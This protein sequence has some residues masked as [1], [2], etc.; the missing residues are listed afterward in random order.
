MK[1][2]LA[3]I[4]RLLH[5]TVQKSNRKF[6]LLAIGVLLLILIGAMIFSHL[7]SKQNVIALI[8]GEPITA[9][10]LQEKISE[11]PDFYRQYAKEL[12][13]Q[14][15]DDYINEQLIYQKAHKFSPRYRAKINKQL[16]RYR[17]ELLIKEYLED[18]VLST[19]QVTQEELKT[20]YNS[21]LND[22]LLPERL[23]LYE[24]VVPTQESAENIIKRLSLGEDFGEI[25]KKES[26]GSAKEKGGDLGIIVR[27]Q[28]M[29]ELEAIVFSMKSGDILGKVVKTENGFHI[30]RVG[31]RFPSQIQSLEEATPNI[32]KIV[33]TQKKRQ[34]LD[35]YVAKLKEDAQV[36]IHKEKL[37]DLQ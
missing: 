13:Q 2:Y 5:K 30:L 20:Y 19:I 6:L 12:P 31:E 26:Q 11:Y 37:G 36:V 35:A 33:L 24:I 3:Q 21:H 32:T 1:K 9:T 14:A 28:L 22:F 25:A 15:L 27:G 16:S 8:N 4:R 17:R 18:Q 10:Q 34:A 23:H 29:P 7:F